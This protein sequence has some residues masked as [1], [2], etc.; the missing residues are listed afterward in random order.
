M[1]E[2]FLS[3]IISFKLDQLDWSWRSWSDCIEQILCLCLV[4]G[5]RDSCHEWN[6]TSMCAACTGSKCLPCGG[7]RQQSELQPSTAGPAAEV[8]STN[9]SMHTQEP[10]RSDVHDLLPLQTPL[11][12]RCQ[13]PLCWR[14][15]VLCCNQRRALSS[16]VV[17]V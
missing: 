1:F 6:C 12:L 14:P 17:H 9:T 7:G 5:R 13:D 15:T 11:L 10:E 2:H 3:A 16:C 8:R 4:V